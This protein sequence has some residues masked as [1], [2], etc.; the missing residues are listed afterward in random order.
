VVEVALWNRVSDPGQHTE[1]QLAVL[2]DW[3]RRREMEIVQVYELQESAWQG[4]HQKMLSQVYLDLGDWAIAGSPSDCVE[5]ITRC[6]EEDGLQYLGLACL[7]LP[8]GQSAR[9][10]YLQMIYEEFVSRLP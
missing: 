7:N 6:H 1:N 4:A 5:L 8:S 2:Q 9:L 3:A 10:E